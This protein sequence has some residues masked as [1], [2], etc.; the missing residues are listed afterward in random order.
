[1]ALTGSI[2][3]ALLTLAIPVLISQFLRLGYQ[4]VDALWVRGLGVDATAAVTSSIFVLWLV[5]SMNDV[6]AMG[7]TAYA[8]QLIGAGDRQRAGLVAYRGIQ[9]S[10]ALGILVAIVGLIAA[11]RIFGLMGADPALQHT[12]GAYLRIVL[13]AA[14]FLMVALT[15]E[16]IMR[17][18]GDTRTP[19]LFDFAALGINAVVAPL[20]IYGVGPF[21]RMGVVGAAWGTF[22]SQVLL[23]LFYGIAALR[24][25]AALPL[26]RRSDGRPVGI[27]GMAR[28]GLPVALIGSMFSVVY[29][30]FA[31]SASQWG[32]ASMAVVGI[33][34]RIEGLQFVWSASLGMATATLVGQSLGADRPDRAVASLRLANLWTAALSV[35]ASLVIAMWPQVFLSLFS[36]DPEVIRVGIPYLRILT[37]CFVLNGLEI[38]T[39]EGI[40]GSGHTRAIS[41]IF[42]IFSLAR[43][44]LAFLF[45]YWTGTGVLG[46]AWVITITC[47]VR[48][49]LILAWAARGTWK[50]GLKSELAD[51]PANG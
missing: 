33:A 39:A 2:P 9:A 47:M 14:P 6:F 48:A 5:M 40:L 11:P 49:V 50:G 35:A 34:N 13:A 12:G 16:N 19:L 27:L 3:R 41:L 18:A 22:F 30:A 25:H 17:A 8:S 51:T 24:G 29:I 28:V 23:V 43:I 26:A 7:V 1:S 10:A 20:L 46:I 15:C 32:P 4:W 44:P 31:R 45:L 42:T 36:N 21:P 38:V 37:L